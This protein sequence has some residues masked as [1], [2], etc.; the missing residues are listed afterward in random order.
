MMKLINNTPK[1]LPL[2]AGLVL[3]LVAPLNGQEL[4]GQ[5]GILDLTANEG[6]NPATGNPWQMG[7]SYHL[8][9]I[10]DATTEATETDIAFYNDFVQGQADAAGY[11]EA[12]WFVMGSTAVTNAID[13]VAITGPII[14]IADQGVIALDS[15]DF[16]DFNFSAT[17]SRPT[18]LGGDRRNIHSGTLGGGLSHSG[19]ELGAADGNLRIAWTGWENWAQAWRAESNTDLKPLAA[20]SQELMIVGSQIS[21]ALNVSTNG[22]NFDFVWESREGKVYDLVSST[23]LSTSPE[24]WQVYQVGTSLYESL[25]ASGT[26][27]NTLMAVVAPEEKRFFALVERNAPE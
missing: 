5:L 14:N 13:N 18:T 19:N 9:F 21:L 25:P 6:L 7:D 11:G 23:D 12:D 26:G 16:W 3:P 4:S 10:T 20:I 8:I 1:N 2:L 27:T 17:P 24:T 15:Q 22:P